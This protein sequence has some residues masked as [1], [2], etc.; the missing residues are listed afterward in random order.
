MHRLPE[1]A[2]D[3]SQLSQIR[4][5]AP[6]GPLTP[7]VAPILTG[8]PP[9]AGPTMKLLATALLFCATAT[10]QTYTLTPFGPACAGTLQGQVVTL[11]NGHG[12]RLGATQLAPNAIAVLVLGRQ[13]TVPTPLPGSTCTLL[14]DPR[15]TQLAFTGPLGRASW[16]QRIPPMLPITFDL[17]VVTLQL[18]P[19]GRLAESTNALTLSGT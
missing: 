14:L 4:P 17:Q 10:A 2:P 9:L 6:F 1:L 15:A 12:L 11:P 18:T 13:S 8:L 3:A 19:T 5:E 16:Q 7:L